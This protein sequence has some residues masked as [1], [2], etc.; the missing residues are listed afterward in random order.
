MARNRSLNA[1]RL[2]PSALHQN[3]DGFKSSFLFSDLARADYA[4]VEAGSTATDTNG[5]TRRRR[6]R[7]RR[8]ACKR[9]FCQKG[10]GGRYGRKA[11]LR[12]LTSPE[13]VVVISV[14]SP[15]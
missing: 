10:S 5:D 8:S 12:H 2:F 13:G 7:A 15:S 9:Q 11:A 6:G 1:P 4:V 14:Q 3:R